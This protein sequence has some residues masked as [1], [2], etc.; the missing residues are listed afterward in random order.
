MNKRLILITLL[1]FPLAALAEP[2]TRGSG[3]GNRPPFMKH[4][5]SRPADD[6]QE[7]ANALAFFEKVSPS[8]FKAYQ[9][10]EEERKN[11][12]RER[13][14]AFYRV[15]Q[16]INRENG[17]EM[18]IIRQKLL[19]AEDEVFDVRWQILASGGPRR[20][21]EEDRAKL[22]EAVRNL[23]ILQNQERALRLERMKKYLKQEEENL[24][25][26]LANPEE[27]IESRYRDE[28]QGKGVGLFDHPRRFDGPGGGPGREG[29]EG[30]DDKPEREKPPRK[31]K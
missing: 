20:A 3:K 19:R 30:R 24:A 21:S 18:R 22:R 17:D 15:N 7:F 1:I 25:A 4:P 31:D 10:L 8:R 9:S 26:A 12:F 11:I 5:A 2:S 27:Q 23:V 6:P 28:L 16:W 13:I 14:I 29:R